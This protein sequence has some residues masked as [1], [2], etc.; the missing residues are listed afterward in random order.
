MIFVSLSLSLSLSLSQRF[1][2]ILSSLLTVLNFFFQ[3]KFL[4]LFCFNYY[5]SYLFGLHELV[6]NFYWFPLSFFFSLT[7]VLRF[8]FFVCSC[9]FQLEFVKHVTGTPLKPCSYLD[10]HED[11]KRGFF[12]KELE[13]EIKKRKRIGR[14]RKKKIKKRKRE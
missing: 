13:K 5:C 10:F 6:A 12:L 2:L 3:S 11:V 7:F 4:S 8:F 14:S 9:L 1:S